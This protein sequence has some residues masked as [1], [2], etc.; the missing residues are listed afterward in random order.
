MPGI[1]KILN[2]SYQ[3]LHG[4]HQTLSLRSSLFFPLKIKINQ[5]EPNAHYKQMANIKSVK[6]QTGADGLPHYSLTILI[7]NYKAF[8]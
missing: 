7:S 6:S 2:A 4:K 8:T 3:L 5:N 1:K